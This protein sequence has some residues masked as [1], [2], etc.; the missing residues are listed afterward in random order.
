MGNARQAALERSGL[1]LML[2]GVV[3]LSWW[4]RFRGGLSGTAFGWFLM[5]FPAFALLVFFGHAWLTHR[6]GPKGATIA[7]KI[8]LLVL[9]VAMVVWVRIGTDSGL[10][11]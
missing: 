8:F 3:A 11:K 1:A 10:A 2:V 9:L 5:G 6:M 4:W 7:F